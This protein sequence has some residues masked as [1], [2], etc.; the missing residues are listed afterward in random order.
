[1]ACLLWPLGMF[2]CECGLEQQIYR[3]YENVQINHPRAYCR[4]IFL[5]CQAVRQKNIID[6]VIGLD[7][8]QNCTGEI[9]FELLFR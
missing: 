4:K 5:G 2:F 6:A 7:Q 1:M 3:I 8:F 9:S